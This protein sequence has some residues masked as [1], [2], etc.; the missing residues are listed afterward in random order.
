MLLLIAPLFAAEEAFYDAQTLR[1][2]FVPLFAAGGGE[3]AD[4]FAVN[5]VDELSVEGIVYDPK[6]GSIVVV[7]GTVLKEG[8]QAGNVKVVKIEPKGATLSVNE[9]EEFKPLYEEN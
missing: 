4:L 3:A 1:D 8:Q 2:P 5:S 7:N 9:I 6:G